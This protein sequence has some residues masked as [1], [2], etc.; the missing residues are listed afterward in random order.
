M[1]D[2]LVEQDAELGQLRQALEQLQEEK[3]K[4]T[5]RVNKLTEELNGEYPLVGF[6]AE[7]IVLP[8]GT[9]KCMQTTVEGSRHNSMCWSKTPG[10][11]G[12]NLTP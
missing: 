7:V 11:R 4:E 10:P 3:A 8:D 5:G 1:N 2:V 9:S 12:T 6:S